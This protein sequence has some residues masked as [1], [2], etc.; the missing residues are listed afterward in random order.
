MDENPGIAKTVATKRGESMSTQLLKDLVTNTSLLLAI[1]IVYNLFFIHFD[2]Q[3]KWL[4]GIIGVFVGGM[5]MLLMLNTVSFS[6]GI[7]F[8]TRSI[9]ISVTGL[10]L[11]YLPTIIA[12]V[13]ISAYRISLGGAG[14]LT[15]VLVT[16]TSAVIGLICYK[17]QLQKILKKPKMVWPELYGW[18]CQAHLT[19]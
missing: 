4:E 14:A 6:N 10:F 13:I 18:R 15:G 17:Y 9:L 3:K 5:G 2:R 7:I 19:Y 11:G 12:T 8:D 16:V 1:S